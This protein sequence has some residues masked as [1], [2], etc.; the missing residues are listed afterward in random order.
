V[1]REERESERASHEMRH[2]PA[3]KQHAKDSPRAVRSHF[4]RRTDEPFAAAE[5]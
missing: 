1:K 4:D 5:A 3:A 2:E